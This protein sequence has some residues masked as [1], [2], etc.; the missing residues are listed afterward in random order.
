MKQ[1]TYAEQVTKEWD[2]D[3]AF[4]QRKLVSG[5]AKLKRIQTEFHH[6]KV[7]RLWSNRVKSEPQKAGLLQFIHSSFH[8]FNSPSVLLLS[9]SLAHN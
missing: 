3:W 6:G 5:T 4:A 7:G 2:W 9:H 1:T 8:S